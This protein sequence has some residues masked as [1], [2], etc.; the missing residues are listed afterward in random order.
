MVA[1][2]IVNDLHFLLQLGLRSHGDDHHGGDPASTREV[3]GSLVGWR[4][5]LPVVV[6]D[7]T[8]L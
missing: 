3:G 1:T 2:P 5:C 6:F 7:I 4:L 8:H